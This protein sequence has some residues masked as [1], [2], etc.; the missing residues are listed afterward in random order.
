MIITIDGGA[1]TGKSSTAQAVCDRTGM[2]YMDSGMVFRG[3]AFALSKHGAELDDA[4][5]KVFLETLDMNVGVGKDGMSIFIDGEDV[6]DRLYTQ[7]VAWVASTIGNRPSVRGHLRKVF[8]SFASEFGESP[9]VVAAGRDMGAVVFPDA[10]RKFFLVA[11]A[12]VRAQRRMEELIEKGVDTTFNDV[13]ESIVKR[14]HQDTYRENAPLEKANDAIVIHTDQHT[15]DS[16]TEEIV[17]STQKTT[18]GVSRRYQSAMT[19]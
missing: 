11:S 13:L 6:S 4:S 1:A 9:G 14:D 2:V 15:L 19:R 18:V 3:V 5:A 16:Q 7:E 12:Q 17:N 8:H 10:G